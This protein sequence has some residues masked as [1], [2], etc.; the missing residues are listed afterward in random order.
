M[1]FLVHCLHEGYRA[2]LA[3]TLTLAG[4]AR[5]R[6][7]AAMRPMLPLLLLSACATPATP[8]MRFIGTLTPAAP[9]AACRASQATL[10]LRDGAVVFNPDEGTWT[11]KGTATADGAITAERT[12]RGAD[13]Q[14]YTTRLNA[15]WTREAATGEYVTPRCTFALAAP[16]R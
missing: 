1:T 15:K 14:P 11:L 7:A 12:V 4:P 3:R 8:S 16:A 9:S 5:P 10:V 2:K 13:R 6:Y